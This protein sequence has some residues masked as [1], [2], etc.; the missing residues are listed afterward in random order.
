MLCASGVLDT[1]AWLTQEMA[2]HPQRLSS[3]MEWGSCPVG[4]ALDLQG[5][6]PANKFFSLSYTRRMFQRHISC[7][8][9]GPRTQTNWIMRMHLWT[10]FPSFFLSLPIL[11]SCFLESPPILARDPVGSR[12]GGRLR[13]KRED[14]LSPSFAVEAWQILGAGVS[15]VKDILSSEAVLLLFRDD[16]T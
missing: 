6:G 10:G 8:I 15:L 16:F 14:I 7:A 5:T 1:T 11:L 2:Q 9:N 12:A 3:E 4:E 13:T